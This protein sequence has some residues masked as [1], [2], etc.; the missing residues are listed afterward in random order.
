MSDL[1]VTLESVLLQGE[2]LTFKISRDGDHL[3]VLL[4]PS[5]PPSLTAL[6]PEVEKARSALSLPLRLDMTAAQLDAEL[7]ERIRGYGAVRRELR[8][9]HDLII[10]ELNQA[11]QEARDAAAAQRAKRK[12]PAA[13]TAPSTPPPTPSNSPPPD[14][15][16]TDAT[17]A[18]VTVANPASTQASLF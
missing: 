18:P 14:S 13:K 3:V 1:F 2:S 9:G 17:P 6:A 7:L 16:D 10:E 11:K 12:T 15:E 8:E 5:L 4:I